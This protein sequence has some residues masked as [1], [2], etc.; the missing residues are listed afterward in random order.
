MITFQTTDCPEECRQ[1][2]RLRYEVYVNEFGYPFESSDETIRD[3]WDDTA[4]HFVL[5]Q[6]CRLIGTAR[7]NDLTSIP[8]PRGWERYGILRDS[9]ANPRS[10]GIASR[11]ILDKAARGGTYFCR[12]L[13]EIYK[14]GLR[15]DFR[16]TYLDA[17]PQLAPLYYRLGWRQSAA[18]YHDAYLGERIPMYLDMLDASHLEQVHSP[19]LKSL[20]QALGYSSG[21]AHKPVLRDLAFGQ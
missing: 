7:A 16:A 1:C 21:A 15:H 9:I 14:W 19:L 4:I 10:I 11:F 5:K 8:N 18:V 17:S 3:D 13:Q 6:G 2:Y 12:F 20:A